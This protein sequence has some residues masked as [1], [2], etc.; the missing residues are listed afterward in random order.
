M[1][2]NTRLKIVA[3]LLT[4]SFSYTYLVIWNPAV[5]RTAALGYIA[6]MLTLLVLIACWKKGPPV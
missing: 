1:T 6:L 5:A 2:P 3:G 4:L